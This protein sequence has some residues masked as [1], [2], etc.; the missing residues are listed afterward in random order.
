MRNTGNR[1]A[2]TLKSNFPAVIEHHNDAFQAV[3]THVAEQL[4]RLVKVDEL[5]TN[6]NAR[7]TSLE[8]RMELEGLKA[9]EIEKCKSEISYIRDQ[10]WNAQKKY[11]DFNRLR[12]IMTSGSCDHFFS[13]LSDERKIILKRDIP[14]YPKY[15]LSQETVDYL[16][17]PTF[18]IWH[19]EPNEMLSLLEHMYHEGDGVVIYSLRKIVLVA[20][21]VTRG[22]RS[23]SIVH[24]IILWSHFRFNNSIPPLESLHVIAEV[25]TCPIVALIQTNSSRL[26]TNLKLTVNQKTELAF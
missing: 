2:R 4:N 10:L 23:C 7:L 1:N 5:K 19:W 26:V 20:I 3:L 18:D 15:T 11:V 16:K 9:V 12:P 25:L 8:K 22:T 6:F 17:Q 13:S 24:G 21:W 14:T